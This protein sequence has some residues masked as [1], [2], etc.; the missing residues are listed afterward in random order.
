M[1][2]QHHFGHTGGMMSIIKICLGGEMSKTQ[3]MYAE[4]VMYGGIWNDNVIVVSIIN[5][6]K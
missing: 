5:M 1:K 2:D 6:K 4:H 3:N